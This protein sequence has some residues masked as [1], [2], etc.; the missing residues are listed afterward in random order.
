[1]SRLSNTRIHDF[2]PSTFQLEFFPLVQKSDYV[3]L[4]TCCTKYLDVSAY[5]S[6]AQTDLQFKVQ[7]SFS[8][9]PLRN[10]RLSPIYIGRRPQ[11]RVSIP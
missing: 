8:Q 3:L 9:I 10:T 5:A 1:M 6:G 4:G 7:S 2:L 11:A